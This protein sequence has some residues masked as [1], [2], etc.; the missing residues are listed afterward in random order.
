MR[1]LLAIKNLNNDSIKIFNIL[2]FNLWNMW[3]ICLVKDY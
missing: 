2:T 1:R 3:R